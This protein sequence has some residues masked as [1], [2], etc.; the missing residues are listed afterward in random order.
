MTVPLFTHLAEAQPTHA[1]SLAWSL[2]FVL[3]LASIAFVPLVNRHWWEK[4]YPAVALGLGAIS[5]A[6]YFLLAPASDK[7]VQ[8]IQSY[9]SFTVLLASLYIVSGGIMINVNRLATPTANSVLLLI[10]AVAANV[11]GTTGASMLLIRPYIRMNRDHLKP[12]HI[13]FFIFLVSN[14]GGLLTPIGDPPLFLGYLSGVP[15]WWVLQHCQ[16]IWIVAVGLLLFVF[17]VIDKIDHGRTPRKK[18]DDPGP[19]VFV[20]GIHNLLFIGLIV[21]AVFQPGV[22][23][24]TEQ[25]RQH[26]LT[27]KLIGLLLLS[28]EIMMALA[29]LASLL[30]TAKIIYHK[31][32][33]TY[34]PIR[35]VAILFLGIFSTMAPAL[36]W[37]HSNAHLLPLKTPGQYYFTTG[38]LSAVLDNAPTYMTLLEAELAGL[39]QAQV[40]R[41]MQ[42]LKDSISQPQLGQDNPDLPTTLRQA[43]RAMVVYHPDHILDRS[44]T[45]QEVEVSFLLLDRK[46]SL[47]LIAI[48]AGAVLFGACTY[49]GNGPNFMVKAIAESA[50][51]KMPTFLGYILCYTLPILIPVYVLV[52][53][54]FLSP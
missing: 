34:G 11:F 13:I 30:L 18:P 38:A 15:F 46:L 23:T 16:L 27:P 39:D 50:N 47:F 24:V 7:W 19:T 36:Q 3:L 20:H 49:I 53:L 37:L 21:W 8:E 5:A 35:E 44:A 45:R 10:G 4:W 54:F 17:F 1:I 12:F 6:Y 51:V 41:A 28:R 14:V 22:F 52:W 48:S 32:E 42:I 31:N 26:G 2:P 40:D 33:F 43:L 25:I 9:L 29:A